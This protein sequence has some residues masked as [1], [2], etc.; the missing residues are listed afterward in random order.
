MRMHVH[1]QLEALAGSLAAGGVAEARLKAEWLVSRALGCARL[2]LP[3]RGRETLDEPRRAT[4]DGWALR[5]RAGEPLQYVLGDTEFMGHRIGTDRRALIPRPETEQLVQAVLAESG[6]RR[7][8]RP[9]IADVGTG[10]GCIAIALALAWPDLSCIATDVSAPA[11]QLARE[12]ARAQ[13][14]EGRIRFVRGSLLHGVGSGTL[15]A[16]VSNP[17]YVTSAELGALP[18]EVRDF[19]P[20]DALDGGPDGLA[21]IS[22][23]VPAARPALKSGGWLFLE[24]GETQADPVLSLMRSCGFADCLVLKDLARRDRIARGRKAGDSG[25]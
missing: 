8:A 23:L 22:R 24:I 11:L 7:R 16:V 4:L 1:E 17:P 13:G 14:V 19:E 10:S 21:V 18:R 9:V 3:L 15:D 6:L 25:S 12:N 20:G 5:L 2:E